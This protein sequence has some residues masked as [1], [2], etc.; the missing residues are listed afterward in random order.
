MAMAIA[1]GRSFPLPV[2]LPPRT[3][4]FLLPSPLPLFLL[5]G[6]VCCARCSSGTTTPAVIRDGPD[7]RTTKTHYGTAL[8]AAAAAAEE[9]ECDR[10]N[11]A[12]PQRCLDDFPL[13]L[14]DGILLR[15][16]VPESG[17]RNDVDACD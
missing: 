10:C 13:C 3:L 11:G 9:E 15:S 17:D 16:I 4:F 12:N 2:L 6:C 1:I 14:V 7:G 5:S 8:V